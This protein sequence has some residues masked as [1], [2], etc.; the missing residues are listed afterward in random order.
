LVATGPIAYQLD[1][2]Q[3][4]QD[5]EPTPC[6]RFR[7]IMGPAGLPNYDSIPFV[8][9]GSVELAGA[10]FGTDRSFSLGL[11]E[12]VVALLEKSTGNLLAVTLTDLRGSYAFH[13]TY[14]PQSV[15]LV[16]I[17][18]GL[19]R[20]ELRSS[21]N[22]VRANQFEIL[23]VPR[24]GEAHTASY[25]TFSLLLDN[26]QQPV[27]NRP[28]GFHS[29]EGN[30]KPVGWWLYHIEVAQGILNGEYDDDITAPLLQLWLDDAQQHV[31]GPSCPSDGSDLDHQL[32]AAALNVVSGRGIFE[33]Y[34]RLQLW[35]LAFA[36]HIYC[37]NVLFSDDRAIALQFLRAINSANDIDS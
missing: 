14:D 26:T 23:G 12:A 1:G 15:L 18:D 21:V 27:Y 7:S 32:R 19:L 20:P 30:S 29:F 2:S 8:L 16:L 4:G 33:P 11:H 5:G 3:D 6:S 37:D 31:Y 13:S 36:R 10:R 24:L 25:P 34:N 28:Q 9:E 22:F 17:E 35:Y